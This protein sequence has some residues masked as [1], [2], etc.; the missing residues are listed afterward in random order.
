MDWM[1]DNFSQYKALILLHISKE[2]MWV[3][4]IES[5]QLIKYFVEIYYLSYGIE[6][7]ARS[8]AHRRDGDETLEKYR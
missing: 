8:I 2:V 6:T 3:F 7:E 4:I 1:G 5:S